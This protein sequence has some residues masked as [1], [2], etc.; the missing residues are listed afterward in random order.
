M[1]A[2]V[3]WD[4]TKFARKGLAKSGI[5]LVKKR[6]DVVFSVG[7][8]GTCLFSE[9]LYPGIPKVFIKHSDDCKRCKKHNINFIINAVKKK[10]YK[11]IKEM[12]IEAT[13]KNK[14][15]VALND[16]NIHYKPPQALRLQ[17]KLNGRI[18]AKKVIGDG[19]VIST[20]YGSTAYFNSITRKTFKN[21]IG[22]AF[23]NP[24]KRMKP[25]IVNK[26]SKIEVKILRGNGFVAV[27]CIK[28]IIPIKDG[29][30]IRIKK[31]GKPAK[32]IKLKNKKLKLKV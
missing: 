23:N 24:V 1:R 25:R 9:Q 22:I 27:D 4:K 7:G 10:K 16:I 21:G 19:L 18:I 14:K 11:I 12:K 2:A 31:H 28:T 8:D 29:D 30:I 13:V 6:P 26:N 5:K 20:P 32:F 3:V 17:V 15:L